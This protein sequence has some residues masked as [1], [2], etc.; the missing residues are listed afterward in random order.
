MVDILKDQDYFIESGAKS[1]LN[2]G[3]RFL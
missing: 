3:V 1:I 2:F